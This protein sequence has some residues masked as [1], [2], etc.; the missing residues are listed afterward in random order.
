M[1][2]NIRT[3]VNEHS[4]LMKQNLGSWLKDKGAKIILN[5]EDKTNDFI[6]YMN[7]F[8]DIELKNEKD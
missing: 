1:E 2:K 8:P 3:K 5:G 4:E 6:Q 7:D